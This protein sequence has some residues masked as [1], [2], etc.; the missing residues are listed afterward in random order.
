MQL[1]HFQLLVAGLFVFAPSVAVAQNWYDTCQSTLPY[2]SGGYLYAT[3]TTDS[4]TESSTALNL[5][6]CVA[7]YG[8]QLACAADGDF[9]ASCD[10]ASCELA[11]EDISVMECYCENGSGSEVASLVD[12]DSCISNDNGILSCY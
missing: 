10:S 6:A 2:V 5:D 8:G 7:N 4:G 12:L 3:C 9:T 11:A 1:T